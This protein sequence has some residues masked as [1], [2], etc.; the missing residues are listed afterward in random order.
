MSKHT[1]SQE[2]RRKSSE[3]H[4]NVEQSHDGQDRPTD[5][6]NREHD[7]SALEGGGEESKH[8]RKHKG[9]VDDT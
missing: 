5:S 9:N 8:G 6:G 3:N 1:R 7:K 2:N 4:Q